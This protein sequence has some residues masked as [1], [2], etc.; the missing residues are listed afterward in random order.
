[1]ADARPS[2]TATSR[3]IPVNRRVP[4]TSGRTP[5]WGSVK[6][7]DHSVPVMKSITLTSLKKANVSPS[8]DARMPTV[9]ST[10][11]AAHKS[12]TTLIASSPQRRRAAPRTGVPGAACDR[13]VA[14]ASKQLLAGGRLGLLQGL[15]AL[16]C[17]L[18][19]HRHDLRGVGDGLVVLGHKVHEPLHL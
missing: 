11:T 8:S 3:A 19:R 17:L 16:G 14:R 5:Y 10:D 18:G 1:M 9:V 7:G 4:P 13:L 6:S 12:S 2:G 15:L